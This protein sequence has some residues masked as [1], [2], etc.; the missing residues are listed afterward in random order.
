MPELANINKSR[1]LE[2][3]AKLGNA[4]KIAIGPAKKRA[5]KVALEFA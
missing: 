2:L 5:G 1:L 3:V 4:I